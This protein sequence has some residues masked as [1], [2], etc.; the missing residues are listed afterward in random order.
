MC[1]TLK[2]GCDHIACEDAAIRCVHA[3]EGAAIAFDDRWGGTGEWYLECVD[4]AAAC[5]TGMELQSVRACGLRRRCS[6]AFCHNGVGMQ[7][8]APWMALLFAGRVGGEDCSA[9]KTLTSA[10]VFCSSAV[11]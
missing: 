10:V 4:G 11:N 5:A 3:D 2:R 6:G 8:E 7:H 9:P 1:T